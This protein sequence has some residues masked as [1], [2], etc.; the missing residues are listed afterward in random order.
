MDAS[1]EFNQKVFQVVGSD[2]ELRTLS[3]ISFVECIN[4]DTATTEE[5]I[6]AFKKKIE[7]VEGLSLASIKGLRE[8]R[9]GTQTTLSSVSATT[10]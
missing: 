5:L 8:T 2:V 3:D 10:A 4:L 1:S 7:D 9:G 6:E